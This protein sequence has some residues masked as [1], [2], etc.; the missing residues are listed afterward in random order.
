M[1]IPLTAPLSLDWPH[2][3]CTVVAVSSNYSIGQCWEGL[4]AG[5]DGDNRG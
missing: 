5:G 1:Y 2:L 3:K 4:G